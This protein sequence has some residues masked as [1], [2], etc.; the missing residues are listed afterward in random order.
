MEWQGDGSTLLQ[1]EIAV[2][3]NVLQERPICLMAAHVLQEMMRL[4]CRRRI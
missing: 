1:E 4:T 2:F 3:T